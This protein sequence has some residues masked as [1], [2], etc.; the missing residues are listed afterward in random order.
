[1]KITPRQENVE[2]IKDYIFRI[3]SIYNDTITKKIKRIVSL[4]NH[5]YQLT[6]DN[7]H[8]FMAVDHI[9]AYL[10]LGY[11]YDSLS[12]LFNDTLAKLQTSKEEVFNRPFY[13]AERIR[14]NKTQIGNMLG[15]WC[16]KK[17]EMKKSEVVADIMRHIVDNDIGTYT[18]KNSRGEF[19]LVIT[20]DE[21]YGCR[22]KPHEERYYTFY[23]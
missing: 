22:I 21:V 6:N 10:E 12:E 1:M 4:E 17:N 23:N 8:L 13:C 14:I 15:R 5:Y 16:Y 3:S 7:E 18:Y 2:I 19:I 11:T 20:A 9:T